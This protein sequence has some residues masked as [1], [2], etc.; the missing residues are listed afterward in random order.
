IS[1]GTE[2]PFVD[3]PGQPAEGVAARALNALTYGFYVGAVVQVDY[4]YVVGDLLHHLAIEL[5]A[6]R[7]VQCAIGLVDPLIH[8]RIA[9]A[10]AVVPFALVSFERNLLRVEP[11]RDRATRVDAWRE[12]VIGEVEV[13][14][15]HQPVLT[16]LA[17]QHRRRGVFYFEIHTHGFPARLDQLLHV[18]AQ[19]IAAGAA[20]AEV[21]LAAVLFTNTIRANLPTSVVQQSPGGLHV[22]PGRLE[23]GRR[24]ADGVLRDGHPCL[25]R[26]DLV[27]KLL[28]VDTHLERLAHALVAEDWMRP[29]SI[30]N[31]GLSQVQEHAIR[32]EAR[33]RKR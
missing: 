20:D 3:V 32:R 24:P 26:Q 11:R 29:G 23:I 17:D 33:D 14:A 27:H 5:L 2:A 16:P 7:L 6:P 31:A 25:A 15:L 13:A 1:L 21:E 22:V 19:G 28:L 8:L 10:H 18:L 9:V 12:A 30:G 4:G